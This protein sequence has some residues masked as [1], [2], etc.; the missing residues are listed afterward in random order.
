MQVQLQSVSASAS[1]TRQRCTHR[2]QVQMRLRSASASAIARCKC[3]YECKCHSAKVHAQ[4]A[5][6]KCGC[7]HKCNASAISPICY[8]APHVLLCVTPCVVYHVAI[9]TLEDLSG[10]NQA[11]KLF[12]VFKFKSF[13][14]LHDPLQS[15]ILLC[16]SFPWGERSV[17]DPL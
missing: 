11:L 10:P 8:S 16:R 9:R 15:L 12:Q 4:S 1:I 5:N 13:T 3:R 7:K 2:M 17:C 6:A 14:I